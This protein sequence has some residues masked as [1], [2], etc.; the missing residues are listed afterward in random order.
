M[1]G[2]LSPDPRRVSVVRSET[3]SVRWLLLV[4]ER[5]AFDP[6]LEED[7]ALR[8]EVEGAFLFWLVAGVSDAFWRPEV[9]GDRLV[10]T[11]LGPSLLM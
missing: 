1:A 4:L 10:E 5:S 11:F 7:F 2:T 6:L 3:D 9:L 8:L